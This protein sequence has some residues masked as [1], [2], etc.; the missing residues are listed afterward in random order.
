MSGVGNRR[1][2]AEVLDEVAWKVKQIREAE[3]MPTELAP[4][5]HELCTSSGESLLV[6]GTVATHYLTLEH[7]QIEGGDERLSDSDPLPRRRG[8]AG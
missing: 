4:N 5:Q 2:A 1:D 6:Y 8:R 3:H 7:P